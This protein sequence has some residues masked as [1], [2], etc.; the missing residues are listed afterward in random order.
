MLPNQKGQGLVEY[1]CILALIAIA[2]LACVAVFVIIP[3]TGGTALG[4]SWLI[5]N[6]ELVKAGNP[7]AIFVLV[8]VGVGVLLIAK[9]I[10]GNRPNS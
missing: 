2:V 4:G 1:G 10:F 8:L 9:W 6:W 3:I 5:Q 7:L